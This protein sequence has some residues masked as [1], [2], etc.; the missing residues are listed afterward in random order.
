MKTDSIEIV[1]QLYI[2]DLY[3]YLLQLSGSPQTAEDLVQD[4]FV[5]AYEKLESYKGERVRAWLF[6]VAYNTYVDWYRK[7]KRQVQTD[8]DL[9]ESMNSQIETSPEEHYLLQ[10]TLAN[11]FKVMNSLPEKSR[12]V[13]LFRDYYDL[14]YQEI[15][16]ILDLNLT[17]IKVTLY[18]ARKKIKEVMKNEL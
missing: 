17:N 13:V 12:Q 16:D 5:K 9:L 18:R 14:T 10:L 2:N 6:R 8:P 1:Y 15:A 11:W 3:K 7:E 4:T